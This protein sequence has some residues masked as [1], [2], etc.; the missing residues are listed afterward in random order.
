MTAAG[1]LTGL[2]F[3]AG[4]IAL[5][6]FAARKIARVEFAIDEWGDWPAIPDEMSTAGNSCRAGRASQRPAADA[7]GTYRTHSESGTSA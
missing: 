5:A 3:G 7:Q 1:I 6:W 2:A 4:I